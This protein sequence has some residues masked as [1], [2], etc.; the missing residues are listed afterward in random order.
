MGVFA[1][2]ASGGFFFAALNNLALQMFQPITV[3][4]KKTR[5]A[6]LPEGAFT[7]LGY[8]FCRQ[9]SRR[10]GSAYLGPRPAVKKISKLCSAISE[11][12]DRRTCPRE[13]SEQVAYLNQRL[14]GWANYFCLGPVVRVYGIVMKH[15]RRR[16]RRWLCAKHKVRSRKYARYPL[17]YLH[18]QLHL[19]ELR[20]K[21]TGLLWAKA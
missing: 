15:A 10:T 6:T 13:V 16:L 11:L 1:S 21:A 5:R 3:N 4:D 18:E 17:K 2:V 20:P 8:T 14:K 9:Y 12:T 7:F 19:V